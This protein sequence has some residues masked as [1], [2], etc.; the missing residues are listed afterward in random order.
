[1]PGLSGQGG[2]WVRRSPGVPAIGDLGSASATRALEAHGKTGQEIDARAV[3]E[4]LETK[5]AVDLAE[6]LIEGKDR[7]SLC[8]VRVLAP[9]EARRFS[10]LRLVV[11]RQVQHCSLPSRDQLQEAVD[12]ERG[13]IGSARSTKPVRIR[14]G[15][16][17]IAEGF[18]IAIRWEV[19][20]CADEPALPR[21][22]LVR[23]PL[24]DRL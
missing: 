7:N 8:V 16:Q 3:G 1:M 9:T 4:I 18:R 23:L 14:D 11:R 21:P 5:G 15:F 10:I 12:R 2:S 13:S 6:I 17:R 20:K 19:G 24:C 22:F